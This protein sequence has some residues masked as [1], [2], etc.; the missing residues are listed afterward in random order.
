MSKELEKTELI[1]LLLSLDF[2]AVGHTCTMHIVEHMN[3]SNGNIKVVLTEDNTH[4]FSI[5][6]DVSKL[7]NYEIG[8]KEIPVY[9]NPDLITKLEPYLIPEESIVV[10]TINWKYQPYE[11][12]LQEAIRIHN[13]ICGNNIDD[14]DKKE[15]ST[16]DLK[17][18]DELCDLASCGDLQFQERHNVFRR[19]A[20]VEKYKPIIE[21]KLKTFELM[22]EKEVDIFSIR[23]TIGF[24]GYNYRM[25]KTGFAY[26]HRLLTQEE[27]DSLKK[28]LL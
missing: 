9:V 28:V 10:N 20:G 13:I 11:E 24:E 26:A 8:T 12:R 3:F 17:A 2:K 23:C 1:D 21:N 15:D 4:I 19:C 14:S 16:S 7:V 25:S 18:L 5:N 22:K 27:Y 6:S